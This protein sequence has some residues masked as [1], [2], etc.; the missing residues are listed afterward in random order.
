[1]SLISCPECNKEISDKAKC[2]PNC[3]YEFH[4]DYEGNPIQVDWFQKM[5]A[6]E[7]FYFICDSC[8]KHT[9]KV[10]GRHNSFSIVNNI[11][12][13]VHVPYFRKSTYYCMECANKYCRDDVLPEDRMEVDYD[14]YSS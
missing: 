3:G 12:S 1:M 2:C 4:T 13:V 5:E 6:Q 8:K 14:S 11:D 9:N 7:G 10:Y